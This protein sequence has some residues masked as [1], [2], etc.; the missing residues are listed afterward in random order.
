MEHGFLNFFIGASE[1]VILDEIMLIPLQGSCVNLD[2]C[3]VLAKTLYFN[4]PWLIPYFLFPKPAKKQ[5]H[6]T[7]HTSSDLSEHSIPLFI[8]INRK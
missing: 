1:S 4:F 5:N 2:S 3:P 8:F 6:R 7:S